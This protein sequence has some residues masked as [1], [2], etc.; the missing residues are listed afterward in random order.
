[1]EIWALTI[2]WASSRSSP[3]V[4]TT[5]P[6]EKGARGGHLPISAN[7][8]RLTLKQYLHMLPLVGAM[9]AENDRRLA[10]LVISFSC[11]LG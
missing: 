11:K 8:L 10:D 2:V 6:L 9:E 5:F 1:M 4:Q 7:L 3:V